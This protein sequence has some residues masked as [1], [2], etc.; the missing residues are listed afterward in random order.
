M[1]GQRLCPYVVRGSLL[2]IQGLGDEHVAA[3]GVYVVDATGRLIGA[4]SSDAVADPYVLILIRADLRRNREVQQRGK[5]LKAEKVCER[6][7]QL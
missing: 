2:S 3:D 4:C 1:E 5:S 6:N 7:H